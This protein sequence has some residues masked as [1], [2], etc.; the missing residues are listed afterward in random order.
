MKITSNIKL[1]FAKPSSNITVYAKQGD[2]D[3]RYIDIT[4][5]LNGAVWDIP[6]GV[7][8]YFAAAKPDGKRVISEQTIDGGHI[9]VYLTDQTLVASGKA[10]CSIILVDSNNDVLST[11]NFN[12]N[13]E[14]SPGVYAALE[15]TDEVQTLWGLIESIETKLANGDF[16]GS[17]GKD[18]KSAYESALDGGY[19]GTEEEFNEDLANVGNSGGGADLSDDVPLMNGEASAGVADEAA[20]IDHVHP[21]DD[22]KMP[23]ISEMS[24]KTTPANPDRFP[25]YDFANQKMVYILYSALLRTIGESITNVEKAELAEYARAVQ[26][27]D[28]EHYAIL[29]EGMTEDGVLALA[30]DIAAALEGYYTA[31]EVDALFGGYLPSAHNTSGTAHNDIRL[32]IQGLSERLN[33]IADSD[34]T[35]L[36]QLSE[37]VAYIKDNRELIE[38]I[39]TSKVSVADIV[40]NLTTNVSNKPLAAAQGVVLKALIDGLSTG[41]LDATAFSST[42]ANY[43]TK[44]Q[45]EGYVKGYAQPIGDY[46]LASE[47]GG[48]VEDA[49][50]AAKASGEFDGADGADGAKWFSGTQVSIDGGFPVNLVTGAK[51]GDYYLNTTSGNV[52]KAGASVWAYE[53]NI[54]GATG[55]TGDAGKDGTSVTVT[56]VSESSDDGGM[57][58]V[59]FSDGST[60]SI[61]N[62]SRGS[63]GQSGKDGTS[64]TVSSVSESS[65]DGGNNVITF[66]DGKTLTVKNGSKGSTGAAGSNGSNGVSATHSW[67]GTT[68]T[69]TSASG[70]SSADLKGSKGDKGDKGDPYTLTTTDRATIVSDVINALPKY[71]GEYE[72]TPSM[73]N[74]VT[75]RMSQTYVDADISIK[76][77]PYSE[78]PN[79][80][81]GNTVYIG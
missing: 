58:V 4:P 56:K 69:V 70:T 66:S 5:V 49:L 46:M 67:S 15:S 45:V 12:L 30:S 54:K 39:T 18:G 21:S 25:Y 78:V 27:V 23:A 63:A 9:I 41:K 37:L 36:D 64:V 48:A 13:I 3:T 34:D 31:D 26:T 75:L 28:G 7:K 38:G 14:Y 51:A 6:V 55:A 1:D 76:K 80:S 73:S 16:N 19:D 10:V 2:S 65:A 11:H 74:D 20:R 81:G 24:S 72:V 60:V 8:A 52:Y 57:N 62:G 22:R 32:L 77:V 42:I 79:G 68:L 44:T 59:T 71:D 17:P 33:A 40:D 50:A 43:Y 29:P 47:L 53:G 61:K 35:T